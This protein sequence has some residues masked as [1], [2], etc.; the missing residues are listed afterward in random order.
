MKEFWF[1]L[2]TKVYFGCGSLDKYIDEIGTLGKRILIVS[3]RHS[4]KVS[5]LLDRIEKRLKDKSLKYFEFCEVEENPTFQTLEQGSEVAKRNSCDCV[6][7][8]GGGSAMDAAKGIAILVTNPG[9][10][11]EFIGEDKFS[12]PPLPIVAIPTTAGTGSEINRYSVIVDKEE[13]TKKTIASLLIMPRFSICDP[14]LTL[15]LPP[16]LT[17]STG[18]DALSHAIE[19][20]LSKKANPISDVLDLEAI[21]LGASNL[22]RAFE[23][24]KDIEA[25]ANMLLSS[26]MAGMALNH[27]GTILAHGMGYA[28]T[29]DYGLQH[30]HASG[31]ILPYLLEHIYHRDKVPYAY[32]HKQISGKERI[33]KI[34]EALGGYPWKV[35]KQLSKDIGM[36]IRLRDIGIKESELDRL[37]QRMLENS[38]RSLKNIDFSF[39][40]DDFKQVARLAF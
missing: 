25:R 20:Y 17:A 13:N 3:G 40:E 23:N 6:L 10:A 30:G 12:N 34:G 38:S 7:G 16:N 22:K 5:G 28:L 31:F 1:C 26:L 19:G 24:G 8:I 15:T 36:P 18:M 29:L 9:P 33:D 14:E 21:R 11:K 32:L 37:S 4:V 35:L 2:N 39:T 27:T